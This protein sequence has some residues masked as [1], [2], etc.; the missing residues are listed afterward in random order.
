VSV[1]FTQAVTLSKLRYYYDTRVF[2]IICQCCLI[3]MPWIPYQGQNLTL[4]FLET[5]TRIP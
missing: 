1:V 5:P 2:R 3:P 4:N